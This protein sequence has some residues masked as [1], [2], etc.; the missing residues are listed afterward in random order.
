MVR[1]SRPLVE[2][3]TLNCHDWFATSNAGVGSQKLMLAQNRLLRRYAL[4]SFEQLLVSIT[5]NPA[6][7]IWLSGVDNRKDAPNE[8]YGRELMELFTL[9]EG[10][11]YTERDVREQARALTGWTS[12][13]K[14]GKGQTDFRFDRKRHDEGTKIVFGKKGT[15]SWR[16]SVAAHAP[17]PQTPAVLRHEAV[18]L[19][20]PGAARRPHAGGPRGAL[21]TSGFEVRPVLEAILR[22][23]A[24]Y[25]GPRMVKPP[26]VYIAGLLRGLGR[27]VDTSVVGLA[28][29]EGAGQRLFYP[30]NVAGWDDSRWLDTNAFRGR[31]SIANEAL[32]KVTLEQ[33]KGKKPPKV[34]NDPETIVQAA[35]A[36]LGNPTIRRRPTPSCS[37]SPAARC[38]ARPAGRPTPTRRSSRTP[39]AS[40]SP[41]PPTSRRAEDETLA[42]CDEHSRAEL[43]RR[44][45]PRRDRACPRSR[46][47]CR[48]PRAR[49]STGARSSPEASASRWPS[50]AASA[51]RPA[52]ASTKASPPPPPRARAADESSSRSS[53]TA[54][55]M[56]SRCSAPPSRTRSTAQLRPRLA[57]A[58]AAGTAFA[59]DTSLM[60]HPS[61]AP[62]AQLHGRA[63]STSCRRSAT[64]TRTSRTS[65]PGTSGRSEPPTSGSS[66]GWLGRYLDRVG[67]ADNP[68]QGL[69]LDWSLQPSLATAKMPVA[70]VDAPDRYDFWARG[71]WGEVGD[72]MIDAIGRLGSFPT[73]GDAGLAAGDATPRA[74]RRSST[75][76]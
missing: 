72:R 63:R 27:G 56:R 20:R 36:F 60:W 46:P 39:S 40:S 5:A 6:M 64:T 4:G 49:A 35:L 28:R 19:L 34:P 41:C 68:L 38:R 31:W 12:T 29:R 76:S 67:K 13:W 10:N 43:L 24:L 14:R 9:G 65:R 17:P 47:A 3:M 32:G 21:P 52:G 50:T 42:C 51:L 71:V 22:H 57:L 54:V 18:E 2:R 53:S 26:V 73:H 44:G 8:N 69:S 59:E 74:S 33:K 55:P 16:D 48:R 58:P 30:P 61:L 70:A 25:T 11:G 23:P 75:S 1:T 66:T 15:F 62:L 45:S 37:H 7:L